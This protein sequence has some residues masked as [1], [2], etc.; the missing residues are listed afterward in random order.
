MILRLC[1]G[2]GGSPVDVT[3]AATTG[4]KFTPT[5]AGDYTVVYSAQDAAGNTGN[6][7]PYTVTALA[8]R[9]VISVDEIITA[10]ETISRTNSDYHGNSGITLTSQAETA[11]EGEFAGAFYN[12]FSLT[13]GFPA[14]LTGGNKFTF[15]VT[16][17]DGNEFFDI[18]YTTSNNSSYTNGYIKWGNEARVFTQSR[19]IDGTYGFVCWYDES[20]ISGERTIM[21]PYLKTFTGNSNYEK[22]NGKQGKLALKWED[23]GSGKQILN[24]YMTR[25]NNGSSTPTRIA[26]FD[27]TW[28]TVEKPTDGHTKYYG[29]DS[30]G[31]GVDYLLPYADALENGFRVK[32]S[33]QNNNDTIP[34]TF[35]TLNGISLAEEKIVTTYGVTADF[36]DEVGVEGDKIYIPQGVALTGAKVTYAK[37]FNKSGWKITETVTNNNVSVDTSN[38]G[39]TSITIECNDWASKEGFTPP[40][41][42]YTATVETAYTV[43]FNVNGGVAIGTQVYSEHTKHRVVVP[44]A[45]EKINWVFKGW[46]T[47]AELSSAYDEATFLDEAE[48]KN[49]YAKWADETDPIIVLGGKYTQSETVSKGSDISDII[50]DIEYY[51]LAQPDGVVLT[52]TITKP[53]MSEVNYTSGAFAGSDLGEYT[54]TYTV[55]DASNNTATLSRTVTVIDRANPVITIADGYKT[56]AF[57]GENVALAT[58]TAV[59]SDGKAIACTITVTF[60]DEVVEKNADGTV[61][62]ANAGSYTVTIVAVDDYNM[63]E[64]R[65]YTITVVA[66]TE[67]PEISIEGSASLTANIGDTVTVPSYTATDNSGATPTVTVKVTCGTEEITV[68][69]GKFKVEKAGVYTITYTAQDASGNITT[70]TVQVNV[71]GTVDNGDGNGDGKKGCGGCGTFGSDIGTGIASGGAII[72]SLFALFMI[73]RRKKTAKAK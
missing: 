53:D 16:D 46:Y 71:D 14:E 62:V 30:N 32:F 39:D 73:S 72:L 60:D 38:T 8:D 9:K 52:I 4:Y 19:A 47:D 26:S 49:L 25:A 18:I 37:E 59:D 58:A 69:D 33:C 22:L 10:S 56:T 51:D 55:K 44:E 31:T 64:S 36:G 45:A 43:T 68:T 50:N 28:E 7:D 34:V 40:P 23:N 42:S 54:I 65:S 27:G 20:R 13:F 41:L 15:T 57:V 11:Y 29:S 61:K 63:K 35:G 5:E 2:N 6:S 70:K 12:D 24:V 3:G 17:I 21:H 66:D 48:N 1:G 67:A